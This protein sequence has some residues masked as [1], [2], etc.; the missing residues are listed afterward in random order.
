[1]GKL[2][3]PTV[4]MSALRRA[5]YAYQPVL[6]RTPSHQTIRERA[7]FLAHEI[8]H[9]RLAPELEIADAIEVEIRRFAKRRAIPPAAST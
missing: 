4:N 7:A 8:F 2:N 5:G 3:T 1:M 6:D 9:D